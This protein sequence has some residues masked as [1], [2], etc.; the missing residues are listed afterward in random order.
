MPIPTITP[1]NPTTL[2]LL[3]SQVHL[4]KYTK[5]T[6]E[7]SYEVTC[8]LLPNTIIL[9]DGDGFYFE[10]KDMAITPEF[11]FPLTEKQFHD[12]QTQIAT[13]QQPEIIITPSMLNDDGMIFVNCGGSESPI[14]SFETTPVSLS[15]D[16]ESA[17]QD[18]LESLPEEAPVYY[19]MFANQQTQRQILDNIGELCAGCDI[20]KRP[21]AHTI[22]DMH[23][24]YG[25]KKDLPGNF[26]SAYFEPYSEISPESLRFCVVGYAND[27]V[28]E[29]LLVEPVEANKCPGYNGARKMHITTQLA[30]GAKAVDTAKLT[31]REIPKELQFH[32][33][34]EPG[35]FTKDGRVVIADN[36]YGKGSCKNL[37]DNED[38]YLAAYQYRKNK[39]IS[40]PSSKTNQ[41]FPSHGQR[42][43]PGRKKE[44][45]QTVDTQLEHGERQSASLTTSISRNG[46]RL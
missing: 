9:D 43:F 33:D 5:D 13:G 25:F 26:V 16:I 12:L 41:A 1:E 4:N 6:G 7:H 8:L 29:G 21:L 34:L 18:W 10:A 19:G 24:T 11:T 35:Y 36:A 31:F 28:N 3:K 38:F 40:T 17:R 32:I 22:K 15:A 27:E 14:E 39:A 44:D 2:K 23:I 42:A 46:K 20:A 30:E 37:G 45:P